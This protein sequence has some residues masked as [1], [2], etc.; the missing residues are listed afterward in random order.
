[1]P[2]L[3]FLSSRHDGSRPQRAGVVPPGPEAIP[4]PLAVGFW[5]DQ[6]CPCGL[7]RFAAP[8]RRVFPT[9]AQ[10][11]I[12]TFEASRG[13]FGMSTRTI[14]GS[15][16]VADRLRARPQSNPAG[17]LPLCW[18]IYSTPLRLEAD[19]VVRSRLVGGPLVA[20]DVR[21]MAA[22]AVT[23][24]LAANCSKNSIKPKELS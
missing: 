17:W 6:G 2:D 14:R 20:A 5:R 4:D 15:C 21:R 13:M 3:R 19:L 7:L 22:I 1:M 18:A 9:I 8:R 23:A 24:T 12:S 11:V 10:A 16:G